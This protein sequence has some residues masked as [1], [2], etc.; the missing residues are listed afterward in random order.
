MRQ[1]V[2]GRGGA[3]AKG[4]PPPPPCEPT[5]RHTVDFPF[6]EPIST[7]APSPRHERASSYS[8][9]PSSSVSQPGMSAIS[10]LTPVWKSVV[11][12]VMVAQPSA[13]L[14]AAAG[15]AGEA[16]VHAPAPVQPAGRR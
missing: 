1:A 14:V 3:A 11:V 8:A 13:R 12:L 10:G 7:I 5:P 9:S 15:R 2:V 6:H 16:L 4:G